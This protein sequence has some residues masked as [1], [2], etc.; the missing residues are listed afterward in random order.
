MTE[1][2][3]L[4][5][6]INALSQEEEQLYEQAGDG[7]GLSEAERGRLRQIK[8]ELDRVYD[9]MHQREARRAAGQNP[10][11]AQLRPAEIVEHYDQ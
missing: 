4:F 10:A 1:D 2:T 8:V 5:D 7:H 11:T 6:R 9:L 3:Q